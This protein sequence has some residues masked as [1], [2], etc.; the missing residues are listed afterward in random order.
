M[1][2]IECDEPGPCRRIC[3]LILWRNGESSKRQIASQNQTLNYKRGG[4]LRALIAEA[5]VKMFEELHVPSTQPLLRRSFY[6]IFSLLSSCTA[7]SGCLQAEGKLIS[8]FLASAGGEASP[9]LQIGAQWQG[10]PSSRG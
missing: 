5:S 1:P 4:L 2:G 7:A 10:C 9:A 8:S 3:F 6:S